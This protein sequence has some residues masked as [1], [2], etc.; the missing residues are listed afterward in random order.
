MADDPGTDDPTGT[1]G[2]DQDVADAGAP[3]GGGDTD[4]TERAGGA[5]QIGLGI[6]IGAGI[7]TVLFAITDNPLWIALGPGL[8]VAFGSAFRR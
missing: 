3:R 4:A 1:G 7:G 8:G 6:A 2:H 5:P